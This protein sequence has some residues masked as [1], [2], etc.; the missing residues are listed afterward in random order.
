[1]R[2]LLIAD[3][4]LNNIVDGNNVIQNWFE[5]MQDIEMAQIALFPGKPYNNLINK[6]FLVT[7]SM[8]VKSIIGKR[9]GYPFEMS[10]EEMESLSS[11]QSVV[12][13]SKVY[14]TFKKLSTKAIFGEIIR[15]TRELIWSIGRYDTDALA[16]FISDFNPDIVFSPRYFSRKQARVEK[17]VSTL[18]KAP[19]IAFSGDDEIS[20][21]QYSFSPLYWINRFFINRKFHKHKKLYSHY[22]T[23]SELQRSEY[24]K[25]YGLNASVLYK[26]GDF[27]KKNERKKVNSPIRMIYAGNLYCNRWKTLGYIGKALNEINKDGEKIILEVYSGD[28]PTSQMRKVLSE[29]NSIYFKGRVTPEELTFIYKKAD[30]ALHVES[31]DKAN[32]LRTRLSFSTKIVDLMTTGCAIMAIAWEEHAALKYL[33]DNDA[34]ICIASKEFILP[35]LSNLVNNPD[36]IAEYG[37][38]AFEIGQRNHEKT[39]TQ[40]FIRDL[41]QSSIS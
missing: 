23:N 3:S 20:F 41:F 37:I 17:I 2:I 8:M 29:E 19:I 13:T 6:Y 4:P 30:I 38:K 32:K 14:S 35:T 31:F 28:R 22:I 40:N 9:A 27:S 7:D 39:K 10:F 25:K 15:N 1:M 16:K 5:G 11:H 36:I 33:K 18:T 21:R 12:K 34:A 24:V 26:C